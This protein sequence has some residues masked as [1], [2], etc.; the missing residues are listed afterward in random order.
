MNRRPLVVAFVVV[1]S[2]YASRAIFLSFGPKLLINSSPSAPQGIYLVT[3]T[4]EFKVGD[5]VALELPP[6]VK[7]QFKKYSWFRE[8][9]LLI[10]RVAALSG[11]TICIGNEDFTINGEVQGLLLKTD[12]AGIPLSHPVGCF[13]LS[14]TQ[15]FPR[16]ELEQSFDGRYFGLLE[17]SAIKGEARLVLPF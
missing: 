1:S 14:S 13:L 11:D 2:L 17:L 4:K 3:E 15:F 12:S 9:Y 16:S 7:A 10:K 5:L 8:D 6:S